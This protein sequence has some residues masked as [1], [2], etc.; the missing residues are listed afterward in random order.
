MGV[1][2]RFLVKVLSAGQPGT[3]KGDHFCG[4]RGVR[5]RTI[6]GLFSRGRR[7]LAR[8]GHQCVHEENQQRD[9][10]GGHTDLLFHRRCRLSFRSAHP[11]GQ[12]ERATARGNYRELLLVTCVRGAFQRKYDLSS[13]DRRGSRPIRRLRSGRARGVCPSNWPSPRKSPWRSLVDRMPLRWRG[14][15][16]AGRPRRHPA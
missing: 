2:G 15:C 10:T 7:A 13:R 14:C 4:R 11:A 3:F 1:G 6:L 8:G 5:G 9:H 12:P 16:S